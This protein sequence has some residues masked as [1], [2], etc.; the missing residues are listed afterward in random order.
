MSTYLV[1]SPYS[2]D[3]VN[4]AVLLDYTVRILAENPDI[5]ILFIYL[6]SK[7]IMVNDA[8]IEGK[9]IRAKEISFNNHVLISKYNHPNLK[10]LPLSKFLDKY[11]IINFKFKNL[12]EVK[13]ISYKGINIGYGVVSSLVSYTRN[14]NPEMNLISYKY[15]NEYLSTASYTV[16][17]LNE[18]LK[19]NNITKIITFNGRYGTMRPAIEIAKANGIS[20]ECVENAAFNRLQDLKYIVY[21]NSMPHG[22]SY[23]TKNINILW[24]NRTEEDV[25]NAISFFERRASGQRAGDKV[26]TGLQKKDLLPELWDPNKRNFVFFTSSEDEFYS[27]GEEWEQLKMFNNQEIAVREISRLCKADPNIVIYLR[28]HPNLLGLKYGY[29]T[30]SECR[31]LKNVIIIPPESAIS[32]YA[33]LFNCEKCITA[34]SSIGIEATYWQIPTILVGPSRYY[35][36]DAAYTPNNLEELQSLLIRPLFPKDK[37]NALKYANS[38]FMRNSGISPDYIDFIP[39]LFSFKG[40]SLKIPGV[41]KILGSQLLF[42]LSLIFFRI[43]NF[44][45]KQ[46]FRR[47]VL[48]VLETEKTII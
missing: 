8:N 46:K 40:K 30:F 14:I 25:D 1:Y 47:N 7:H 38:L 31:K 34:G 15:I 5:N 6:D 35:Y 23:A 19:Q 11:K 42:K 3:C 32:S 20:Y 12:N 41:M 28:I 17:G 9:Y 26:Y 22:I 10:Y 13:Q 33:L 2:T 44:I 48:K 29:A 36:I 24:E 18:I 4:G 39:S 27:I 43:L 45:G 16:D 21:P 37:E